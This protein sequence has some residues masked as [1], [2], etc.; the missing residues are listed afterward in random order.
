MGERVQ[1]VAWN[2]DIDN[3]EHHIQSNHI[4]HLNEVQARP[5]K[6]AQFNNGNLPYELQVQAS[7]IIINKG[8]CIPM[9]FTDTKPV[10]VQFNDIFNTSERIISEGYIKTNFTEMHN[11]RLN[12]IIGCGSLTNEKYK[13]EVHII[14]FTNEEYSTFNIK[15]IK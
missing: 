12:K 1:V 2:N 15:V 7:T 14:N 6:I 3:I 9:S 4:I 5:L 8:K 10:Y 11:N 13:I